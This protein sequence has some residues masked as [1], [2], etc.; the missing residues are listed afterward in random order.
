MSSVELR[1][2]S[3]FN[4]SSS[5]IDV[6]M[7]CE[8]RLGP[9]G[10]TKKVEFLLTPN[11]TIP[12]LGCP[13]LTGLGLVMDWKERILMDDQENVVRCSAVHNLKN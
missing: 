4:G 7:D 6:L 9:S 3:G 10:G 5:P 1:R 12:I 2:F 8:I 13:T 11:V